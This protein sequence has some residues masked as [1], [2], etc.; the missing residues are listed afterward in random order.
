MLTPL[1]KLILGD[2]HGAEHAAISIINRIDSS[3][4]FKIA[5]TDKIVVLPQCLRSVECKAKTDAY[6]GIE[7]VV[8]GKCVVGR[9]K[10][11]FPNLRVFITP[12]GTFAKRIVLT[13]K[14][15]A[16]LGVACAVELYEGMVLCY[17]RQIAVQGLEL[18]RTGCVETA[19]NE[20]NLFEIVRGDKG[21]DV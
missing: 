4:Y 12:G 16:V 20:K 17:S 11:E 13:E 18:L 6:K 7:C 15:K 2:E 3:R 10:K 8:C 9:L 19:V 1:A 14:P 5:P 21:T